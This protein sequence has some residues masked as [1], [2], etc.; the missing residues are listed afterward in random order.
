MFEGESDSK[1]RR[2]NHHGRGGIRNTVTHK[3]ATDLK[4][5]GLLRGGNALTNH[6]LHRVEEITITVD[7]NF[8]SQLKAR[9]AEHIF[10]DVR[11]TGGNVLAFRGVF[12]QISYES[13]G[14]CVSPIPFCFND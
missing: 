10:G 8:L 2:R 12:Q 4:N 14:Q 5:S 1:H 11:S 6:R 9:L 13:D 7:G 3:T